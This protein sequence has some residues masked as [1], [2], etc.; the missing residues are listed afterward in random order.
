[1]ACNWSLTS[2]RAF[3]VFRKSNPMQVMEITIPAVPTESKNLRPLR[4]TR[5]TA[6]GV[7][8]KIDEIEN[9][10]AK[11]RHAVAHSGLDQNGRIVT[12]DRIDAGGLIA[13]KDDAGQQ[14]R[15]DIFAA[16]QRFSGFFRRV[17]GHFIF[18]FAPRFP[19]FPSIPFP[20]L[21][22]CANARRAARAASFLPRRNSQRG[23]SATIKVRR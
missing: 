21:Q 15:N 3:S 6:M 8:H 1:M 12:D 7:A 9:N 14:K 23:D 17:A 4:S 22:C 18:L 20:P 10:G 11:V 2:T 16:K 5:K 13:G 19:P